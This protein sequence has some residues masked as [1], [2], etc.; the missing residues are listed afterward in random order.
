MSDPLILAE[1]ART[2][3]ECETRIR[4]RILGF[5][6]PLP[7]RQ[8]ARGEG[9]EGRR[10]IVSEASK[11]EARSLPAP[12]LARHAV[13][14]VRGPSDFGLRTLARWHIAQLHTC[15]KLDWCRLPMLR[16]YTY[17][18]SCSGESS[19]LRALSGLWHAAHSAPRPRST[20][21]TAA[22]GYMTLTV[23][24]LHAGA[25]TCAG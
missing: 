15:S 24:R 14:R 1:A 2:V 19:G 10:G 16:V 21:L 4:T 8:G 11:H 23:F 9:E 7:G 18:A 12:V 5:G 25:P 17:R 3:P 20:V 13:L 22:V 6:M